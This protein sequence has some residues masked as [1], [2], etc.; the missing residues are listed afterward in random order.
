MLTEDQFT[1]KVI[2]LGGQAYIAG[3]WVRDLLL[4]RPAHDKDYVVCGLSKETFENAFSATP[5]GKQF[6]VYL[7]NIDGACREVALAR[8]ERKTGRGYHGFEVEFTPETTIEEDLFRRD[9]RMNSM[10]VHLP[11]CEIVDPFGGRDDIE[12]RL[13]RATSFHFRDDPVRALR[14]VRQAAQLGFTVADDTI[15]LMRE[16]AVELALEPSERIF[17][18]MRKAL[19]SAQPSV[20]FT[21]LRM[22]SLLSPIFPELD[23]LCDVEQPTL[24]HFGLDAFEHTMNV[25]DRTATLSENEITRFAALLHDLGKGLTPR[26][27]WPHHYGHEKLG[28][29]ALHS[30]NERMT[31][32]KPWYRFASFIIRCH[33]DITR[34]KKAGKIIE[35]LLEMQK[36]RFPP[37]EVAAVITADH[38]RTPQWLQNA[39]ELLRMIEEE[40]RN[41]VFPAVISPSQRG[42]WLKMILAGKLAPLIK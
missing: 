16:C 29:A 18:E 27:Q 38:D 28:L 31:L 1:Q 35:L 23:A 42:D 12:N 14:A 20:F 2:A 9:T 33:M 6:P 24:Y 17:G 4:D 3:G 32:P 39:N 22:A 41:V 8:T 15:D 21:T 26:E 36:Y 10:A 40:R 7:L 11:D 19:Q 30:M 13:V 5:T 37:E 25:L 34:T